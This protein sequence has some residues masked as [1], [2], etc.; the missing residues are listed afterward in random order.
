MYLSPPPP[1]STFLFCYSINH[2]FFPVRDNLKAAFQASTLVD[3]GDFFYFVADS[4][5]EGTFYLPGILVNHNL[6]FTVAHQQRNKDNAISY[7]NDFPF[8][9]GYTAENLY[10]M[11]LASA[12]YHFPIAYPDMGIANTGYFLRLRTNL[13]YAHTHVNDF[14]TNGSPLKADFRSTGAELFFDTKWFNEQPVTFGFRY[15]YL[16]NPDFF[17]GGGRNRFEF[18]LPVSIF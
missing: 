10:K 15:S 3:D 14:Y 18:V 6:V 12:N 5:A 17:G 7:S 4:M 2:F 1:P 16:L 9:R 13:F 11:N 8:S